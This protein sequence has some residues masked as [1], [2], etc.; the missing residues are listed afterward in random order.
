[1]LVLLSSSSQLGVCDMMITDHERLECVHDPPLHID[2][3][4]VRQCTFYLLQ[5]YAQTHNT[6]FSKVNHTICYS[7]QSHA[8][9]GLENLKT[10]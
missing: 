2:G 8:S 5:F 3:Y 1:M 7:I 10:A 9:H 4:I 6:F